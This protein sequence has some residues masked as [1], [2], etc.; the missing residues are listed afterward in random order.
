[1]LKM[2]TLNPCPFPHTS[3]TPLRYSLPCATPEVFSQNQDSSCSGR[4]VAAKNQPSERG[5]QN[6]GAEGPRSPGV[7]APL[8]PAQTGP[9]SW[10]AQRAQARLVLKSSVVLPASASPASAPFTG[11]HLLRQAPL[12]A[13]YPQDKDFSKQ[14]CRQPSIAHSSA[15]NY[16]R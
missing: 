3:P 4:E 1:M 12:L 9:G 11:P 15:C 7:T 2:Q 8:R 5:H 13:Y 10:A 14:P 6:Q 16:I